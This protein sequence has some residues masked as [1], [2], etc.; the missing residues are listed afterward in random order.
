MG[1]GMPDAAMMAP[2][3][4][5]AR[6]ME[7]LDE[8]LLDDAFVD[9]GLVIVENFSPHVFSGSTAFKDWRKGFCAHARGLAGLT[10]MFGRAQDFLLT[11]DQAYFSLPTTWTGKID[12]TAFSEEGG[13]AF[14]LEGELN[15][16][17]IKS[18]AWAVTD[19]SMV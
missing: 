5:V 11:G 6:F 13:W 15:V 1:S 7:T 16:W 18:Y 8:T 2:V 14:V 10:H 17:R 3:T 19:F 12:G 4:K 9:S